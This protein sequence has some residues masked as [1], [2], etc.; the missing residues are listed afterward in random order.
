[1]QLPAPQGGEMA[2]FSLVEPLSMTLSSQEGG[3]SITVG[4]A[5]YVYPEVT[6]ASMV[7]FGEELAGIYEQQKRNPSDP[8]ELDCGQDLSW[9]HLVK[10]YNLMYGMGITN[11]TFVTD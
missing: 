6:T 2:Q 4:A 7:S 10:F 1:M 8:V 5:E 3:I 11:I 9:E